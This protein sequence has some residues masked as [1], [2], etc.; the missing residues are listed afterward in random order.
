MAKPKAKEYAQKFVDEIMAMIPEDAR[1]IAK[2]KVFSELVLENIGEHILRQS[3]YDR[4]AQE[5]AAAKAQAD[6]KYES[7]KQW[8]EKSLVDIAKGSAAIQELERIKATQGAGGT[9]TAGAATDVASLEEQ[10]KRAKVVTQD[11]AQRMLTAV[12][13][14]RNQDQLQTIDFATTLNDL[15][16]QHYI[17]YKEKLDPRALVR[18]AAEKQKPLPVAYA[19]MTAEKHSAKVEA[20][21]KSDLERLEK[22]IRAK[23]ASENSARGPYPIAG[24]SEGTSPLSG[25]TKDTIAQKKN[26][27]IETAIKEMER[28]QFGL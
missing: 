18:Y 19:E 2:D 9:Q 17:D 25:L 11:D 4:L 20:D 8:Y 1:Q 15:T 6:G 7:N 12:N 22:E 5:A 28:M 26:S 14:N 13:T 21:K 16:M 3:D 24:S 27:A 10:L 23:I